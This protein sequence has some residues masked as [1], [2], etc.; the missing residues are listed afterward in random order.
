MVSKPSRSQ[1]FRVQESELAHVAEF[2]VQ[3]SKPNQIVFLEGDPGAGKTTLINQ[4]LNHLGLDQSASPTFAVH[5][6]ISGPSHQAVRVDHFDLY[7][8]EDLHELET[9]GIWDVF[10]D[11]QSHHFIL[12]EWANKFESSVW[13]SHIDQIAVKIESAADGSAR[14]YS[15]TY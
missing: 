5:H 15:V 7:R 9:T 13:P 1:V 12:I 10:A 2:I 11:L 4:I 3:N 14:Q 8:I 6:Q